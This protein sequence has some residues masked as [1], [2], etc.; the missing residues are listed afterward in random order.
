VF[1]DVSHN[2]VSSHDTNPTTTDTTVLKVW[3]ANRVAASVPTLEINRVNLPLGGASTV[4]NNPGASAALVF[5][6]TNNSGS[7]AQFTTVDFVEIV[8]YGVDRSAG[9]R[10]ALQRMLMANA[11][12]AP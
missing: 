5:G 8:I 6:A 3:S 11:G 12:L 1:Y 7:I 10:Q 4:L 9:E 2:A